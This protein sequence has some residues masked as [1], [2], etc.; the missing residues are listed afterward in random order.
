MRFGLLPLLAGALV[1]W[2]A[3][4]R[5][6]S[7]SV[8]ISHVVE[9]GETLW[10]IAAQADIY[11]DP[12]LWPLIY[13]FNRD[14]IQDPARIYPSQLLQIPVELDDATRAEAREAAGA[15]DAQLRTAESP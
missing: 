10:S 15:P 14:Q 7:R 1:V 12:F 11:A 5:A 2:P 13:K 3:G 6:E 8:T 9:P 4:P